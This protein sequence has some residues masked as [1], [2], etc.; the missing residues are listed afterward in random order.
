[1]RFKGFADS[2]FL[3]P[4]A[5]GLIRRQKLVVLINVNDSTVW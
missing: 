1:L 3:S 5:G 2:A 4:L